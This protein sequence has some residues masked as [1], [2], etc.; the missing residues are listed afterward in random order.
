MDNEIKA[1]PKSFV[2]SELT[3]IILQETPNVRICFK[4]FQVDNNADIKKIS[5]VL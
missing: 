4:G 3:P 1:T 5:K 2:T